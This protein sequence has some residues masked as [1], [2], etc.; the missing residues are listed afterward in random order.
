MNQAFI[1][2]TAMPFPQAEVRATVW[3]ASDRPDFIIAATIQNPSGYA[4]M[5]IG[6]T[7]Q[8]SQE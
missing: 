4:A 8:A 7:S 6:T 3:F 2:P 1:I 5:P